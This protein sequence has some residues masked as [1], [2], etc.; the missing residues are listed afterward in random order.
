MHWCCAGIQVVT[1]QQTEFLAIHCQEVGGKNYEATMQHVNKFIKWVTAGHC[2]HCVVLEMMVWGRCDPC[3]ATPTDMLTHWQVFKRAPP[4][5]QQYLLHASVRASET[6]WFRD[7]ISSSPIYWWIFAKLLS[8]VHLGTVM[9]W[10]GFGIKGQGHIF[11]ADL[12]LTASVFSICLQPTQ[13]AWCYTGR[14]VF[15]SALA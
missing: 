1:S 3:R 15:T 2:T 4:R 11:A 10:F 8:L 13:S 12:P 9:N 14:A 7:D 5:L 6:L